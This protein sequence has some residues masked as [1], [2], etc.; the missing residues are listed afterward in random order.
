[1]IPSTNQA[2]RIGRAAYGIQFHFEAN[3]SVVRR[4]NEVFADSIAEYHPDWPP[5]FEA[6]VA[7]H[8]PAADAEGLALARAW[9]AAI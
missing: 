2:F 6:E 9:V 4:W 7:R 1:M 3:S 5:R 8:A